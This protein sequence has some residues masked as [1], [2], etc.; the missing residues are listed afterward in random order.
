MI[1]EK[2]KFNKCNCNYLTKTQ[3]KV[4]FPNLKVGDIVVLWVGKNLSYIPLNTIICL[5]KTKYECTNI[6][7]NGGFNG[8]INTYNCDTGKIVITVTSI[9]LDSKLENDYYGKSIIEAK[10]SHTKFDSTNVFTEAHDLGIIYT[11]ENPDT[12]EEFLKLKKHFY[13][14]LVQYD[15]LPQA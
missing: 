6:N 12:Y 7:I 13:N 8:Y 1:T 3:E 10:L 4:F 2:D 11:G 9:I 14:P 5:G 15:V